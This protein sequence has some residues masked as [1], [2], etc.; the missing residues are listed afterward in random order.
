MWPP[1]AAT[2]VLHLLG[3][4]RIKFCIRT[5]DILC[6]SSSCGPQISENWP[7]ATVPQLPFKLLRL[8]ELVQWLRWGLAG[9][10]TRRT[11]LSSSSQNC[12]M[13]FK[14][15]DSEGHGNTLMLF[16]VRKSMVTLAVWNSTWLP[17]HLVG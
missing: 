5:C 11:R 1:C 8:T 12:S 4:D 14:S 7:R 10:R 6:H 3:M 13:G 16:G 15:G 2:A 17:G 9:S